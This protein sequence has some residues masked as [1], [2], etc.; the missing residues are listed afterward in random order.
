[1][2][3]LRLR[4]DEQTQRLEFGIRRLLSEERQI[5]LRLRDRLLH[6]S[7]DRRVA[8][9]RRLVNQCWRDLELF[10]QQ[11]M[12]RKR[13]ALERGLAQLDGLSP[14]AVLARGYSITTSWPQGEVIRS[15]KQVIKD[16]KVLIRLHQGR[17]RCKV[18]KLEE[19]N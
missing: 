2:A 3:D 18:I 17:L 14:L 1:L 16:D 4:L 7:P 19:T 5:F 8:D 15:T 12:Q 10:I 13:Q 11:G 9:S 6:L